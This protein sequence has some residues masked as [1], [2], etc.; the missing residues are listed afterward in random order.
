[1]DRRT[2]VAAAAVT[3]VVVFLAG[4]LPMWSR[5]R[6]LEAELERTRH[7][8]RMAR[9]EGQLGAALS[10]SL[11]SNYE[12]SR[13]LMADFFTTLQGTVGEVREPAQ[14]RALEGILAQRD[15]IIT[16]LSRA[17][18]ESTQRL[19]ILYTTYFATMDPA[20]AGTPPPPAPVPVPVDTTARGPA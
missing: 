20:G 13:Q 15:E 16:L 7:D 1:M 5:A 6:S 14:R 12:R 18:P 9:L 4:F 2:L 8:L 10:E 11:R 17:Q 3:A 19:M